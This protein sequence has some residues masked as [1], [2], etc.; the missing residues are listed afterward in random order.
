MESKTVDM[1]KCTCIL[2]ENVYTCTS[3]QFS[4]KMKKYHIVHKNTK[5]GFL[6]LFKK[7][8]WN[9]ENQ[10]QKELIWILFVKKKMG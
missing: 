7:K 5:N 6:W 1:Y 8:T 2:T 4:L 9:R 10:K 3:F